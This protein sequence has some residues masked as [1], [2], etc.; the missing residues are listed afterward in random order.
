MDSRKQ[1][2]PAPP[3]V[4]SPPQQNMMALPPPPPRPPPNQSQHNLLPPPPP[5]PFPGQAQTASNGMPTSWVNNWNRIGIPPPPPPPVQMSHPNSVH[6]PGN[7]P[8]Q[9]LHPPALSIPPR[10]NPYEPTSSDT[11]PL[12]SATYIPGGDSF[13]PGVGIPGLHSSQQ[14]SFASS[15]YN[16]EALLEPASGHPIFFARAHSVEGTGAELPAYE[17]YPNAHEVHLGG[18]GRDDVSVRDKSLRDWS[19]IGSPVHGKDSHRLQ[20]NH[21]ATPRAVAL[22]DDGPLQGA[23]DS[24]RASAGQWTMEKVVTW[25]SANG[26]SKD[27]QDAFRSLKLERQSFLELGQAHGG[28]GNF[29]MMHNLVY[30]AL[31]RECVKSGTGFDQS[32]ERDEGKRMRRLIRKLTELGPDEERAGHTRLHSADSEGGVE[33]SPSLNTPSTAGAGEESPGFA[34]N[35]R[36]PPSALSNRSMSSFRSQVYNNPKASASESNVAEN[37]GNPPRTAATREILREMNGPPSKGHSPSTSGDKWRESGRSGI[38]VSS[39]GNSPASQTEIPSGGALQTPAPSRFGHHKTSSTDSVTSNGLMTKSLWHDR[40]RGDDNR[41]PPTIAPPS[42]QHS[43]G[44][45]SGKEQNKG[46]LNRLR[47]RR[48]DE[49]PSAHHDEPNLESPTSPISLHQMV[50]SLPSDKAGAEARE[51]PSERPSSASAVIDERTRDRLLKRSGVDRRYAL[52]TSDKCNYRLVDITHAQEPNALRAVLCRSLNMPD[53]ST[54]QIFLT[55]TGQIEH[56]E[57]LSDPMLEFCRRTWADNRGSLKFYACSQATPQS[58]VSVPLPPSSGLG[59][60]DNQSRDLPS[61]A[62]TRSGLAGPPSGARS[63]GLPL[64]SPTIGLVKDRVKAVDTG[65][66]SDALSDADR[67]ASLEAA[68][69][70]YR[71]EIDKKQ[72][73]YLQ[74]RQARL[75]DSAFYNTRREKIIDFDMPRVSPYEDKKQE[76]LVPLR[77]PPPAPTESSTLTK[78]NS[79]S[80]KAGDRMKLEAMSKRPSTD[81]PIAEETGE[82]GRKAAMAP[83]PSIS[84]GIGAALESAGQGLRSLVSPSRPHDGEPA[85]NIQKALQSV[86]FGRNNSSRGSSPG[87]SPQSPG[88]T[89]G[90]NRMLFKIPDY[91][92]GQTDVPQDSLTKE[93]SL[94]SPQNPSLESLRRPSPQISPN[95]DVP[96]LRRPSMA[97]RRSY[98]P[99]FS[100][101]ETEVE[102]SKK[103]ALLPESDEDSDDGLFARPLANKTARTT[104]KMAEGGIRRPPLNVDTRG[105]K[106]QSVTFAD[107][108]EHSQAP[109]GDTPDSEAALP[110]MSNTS[111][112]HTS[113]V[114]ADT[115]IS[116]RK[117]L[118]M[119]DDVWANRPPMEALI[120]D[121]DTYFPNIDLDQPVLEEPGESPPMSP[122]RDAERAGSGSSA[123]AT[124]PRFGSLSLQSNGQIRARE[125]HPGLSHQARPLSIATQAI[126]EEPS[127]SDT[128]GSDESTLKSM[129]HVRS[130]AQR[131]LTRSSGL[132]RMKSIREVAKGA[133]QGVRRQDTRSFAARSG[134]LSRRKSTKMFGANI[135][136]INPGRGSRMSLIEAVQQ[137]SPSKRNNTYRVIRGQLIGKGTYGRVYVGINATTG[138]VLAIKQVEVNTKA[139]GQDKDKIKDMVGSL[140]REIDTMQHLE[141]PNIVQ[142]L[143]CERK[144]YS[145]SIFLEYISGGSIGSCL[146][147]HGKFEE[148]VVSSLT[149]QVLAGLSYLHGQGIL[150]RDLKADNILLDADGTCKISDFGISKRSDDIYGNDV[151]NSMQGSVFWMAPEVIRSQGQG[152]SAKVD[153]W[154]LGCVVLEMFAGR[155]PWSKEE[156]IGAIYKLGSLGQAPPIPDDVSTSITAEAVAFMWDCFTVDPGE[157]PTADTLFKQH[158]FCT[159]DPYYNFLDTELHDKIREIKEFK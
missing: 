154:S 82:R 156:A 84:A 49:Y 103:P 15:D 62:G 78:A 32:R 60:Y 73:A 129:A 65:T 127:E 157:R 50:P 45:P 139:A 29:G 87:G 136:Q 107:S 121:L 30:P 7:N 42:R 92:D 40:R 106:V 11:Q 119:R 9:Q 46:L 146:R 79:L 20:G 151:T 126:Q 96:S 101:H 66:A 2:V 112:P 67:E 95:T 140:D 90:K 74:S 152:Y 143:G 52:A 47:K 110:I 12:T 35:F 83:T 98:G 97:S 135:V 94:K 14:P 1:Y 58:A 8:Y 19:S 43:D 39:Q 33:S 88:F 56:E 10:Q 137:E 147:K 34:S 85:G 150:H 17:P 22:A 115:K 69:K 125:S 68:I 71:R 99:A 93:L 100:V 3:S 116:R 148:R 27:W 25:L 5:G 44:P 26:F 153:I 155:R 37:S 108:P 114:S 59:I 158:P 16:T 51:D 13:G 75:R 111:E 130:V 57:S 55:E 122:S 28:R 120:N 133:N 134:D 149:R 159:V 48:K 18:S 144:E 63:P 54:I 21:L 142:Y 72:K 6:Y 113:G 89:Y 81:A 31:A 124:T 86:D 77:K 128:L 105:K 91:E 41:Q 24:T 145:I 61:P 76:S 109:A 104:E 23:A 64:D 118:L 141:H 70:E 38:D 132:G 102:F 117:S 138:E 80:K 123:T 131:Q 4:L 36:Y 53:S